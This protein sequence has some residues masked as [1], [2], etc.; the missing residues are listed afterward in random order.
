MIINDGAEQVLR[1]PDRLA[2]LLPVGI[3]K[4]E[5]DFKRGDVIRVLGPGGDVVGY[6]RAEYSSLVANRLLGQ[7]R[8]KPLI[9]YD[10]LYV[11]PSDE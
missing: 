9:H 7:Q 2:S 8:Q 11:F 1:S 3:E 10:Y 5:G 4:V 6:G